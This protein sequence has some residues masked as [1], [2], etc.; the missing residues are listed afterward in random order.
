MSGQPRWVCCEVASGV[1]SVSVEQRSHPELRRD[2]RQPDFGSVHQ[3]GRYRQ[4]GSRQQ[5][6]MDR[7]SPWAALGHI[8]DLAASTS[9][10][11]G[12]IDYHEL[13]RHHR[14]RR[15]GQQLCPATRRSLR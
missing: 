1:R 13:Q 10:E 14:R 4:Q 11:R 3:L 12:D 8:G 7:S 5:P 15:A 6:R 2:Y 9:A